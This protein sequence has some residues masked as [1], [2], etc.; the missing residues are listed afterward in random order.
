MRGFMAFNMHAFKNRI[1]NCCEITLRDY[2][3]S[4]ELH[5]LCDEVVDRM[6]AFMPDEMSVEDLQNLV[7]ELAE[8][9]L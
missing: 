6:I 4:L 3:N 9:F 1:A 5:E 2:D 7:E 8:D